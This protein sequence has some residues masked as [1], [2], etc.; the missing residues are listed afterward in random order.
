MYVCSPILLRFGI[1]I[2]SML[3]SKII[4]KSFLEGVWGGLGDGFWG[5][6]LVLE[7][8]GGILGRSGDVL[9]RLGSIL[10][11]LGS[12]LEAS[13][14]RLGASWGRLGRDLGL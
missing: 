12:V 14:G 3:G 11:R 7:C 13:W 5:Y 8:L 4:K 6:F 2:C 10:G 9:K 1:P